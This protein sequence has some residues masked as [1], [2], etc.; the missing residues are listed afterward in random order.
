M[1]D[2]HY[3]YLFE[4]LV[5]EPY[6]PRTRYLPRN[7]KYRRD[8]AVVNADGVLLNPLRPHDG[9]MHHFTSLKT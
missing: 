3:N 7:S 9:L 1:E 6:T 5:L 8:S 4:R 2:Q